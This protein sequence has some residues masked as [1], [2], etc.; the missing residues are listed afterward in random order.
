MP[1]VAFV[2]PCP[3]GH[4]T[5]DW[6]ATSPLLGAP[7]VTYDIRCPV[8]HNVTGGRPDGNAPA[9]GDHTRAGVVS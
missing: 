8:R 7:L 5:A 1:T 2:A 6:Q 3:C 9:A 4:Q